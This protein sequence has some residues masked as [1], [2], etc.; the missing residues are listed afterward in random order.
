MTIDEIMKQ[1]R[2]LLD[3]RRSFLTGDKD[4]DEIYLKDIKALGIVLNGLDYHKSLKRSFE[5]LVQQFAR[6]RVFCTMLNIPIPE[7]AMSDTDK[8]EHDANKENDDDN[9]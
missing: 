3:D 8:P 7:W 2:E 5:T 4:H 6:V 1:L 9:S